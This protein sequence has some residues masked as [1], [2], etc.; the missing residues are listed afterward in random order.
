MTLGPPQNFRSGRHPRNNQIEY[1]G[2]VLRKLEV[3]VFGTPW[4]PIFAGWVYFFSFLTYKALSQSLNYFSQIFSDHLFL[5]G[6]LFLPSD[7]YLY[8][9]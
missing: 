9:V 4:G 3:D 7:I 2:D 5:I 1:L 8:K 6:N